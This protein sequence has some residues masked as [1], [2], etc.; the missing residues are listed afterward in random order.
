MTITSVI[1]NISAG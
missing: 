1:H